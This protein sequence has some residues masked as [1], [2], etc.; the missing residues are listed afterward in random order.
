[1]KKTVEVEIKAQEQ[2]AGLNWDELFV[3]ETLTFEL[4]TYEETYKKVSEKVQELAN[5]WNLQTRWNYK[6]QLQDYYVKP[7]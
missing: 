5:E 2:N 1:M 7:F 6:G 4:T 3:Y